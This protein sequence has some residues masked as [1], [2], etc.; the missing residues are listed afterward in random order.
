[1]PLP[2]VPVPTVTPLP[3]PHVPGLAGGMSPS[4]LSLLLG[5]LS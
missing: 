3:V 4:L 2:K 5:G 1:V